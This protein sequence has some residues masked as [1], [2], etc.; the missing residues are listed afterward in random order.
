ME[1]KRVMEK[2]VATPKK[3]IPKGSSR[4]NKLRKNTGKA[5]IK[6]KIKVLKM[7]V[8]KSVKTS[9]G[10]VRTCLKVFPSLVM[11]VA[12]KVPVSP[13]ETKEQFVNLLIDGGKLATKAANEMDI[14]VNYVCKWFNEYKEKHN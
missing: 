9:I 1:N 5:P 8:I 10:K 11:P 12:E 2:A 6:H 13:G 3:I 14:N 7:R 4:K